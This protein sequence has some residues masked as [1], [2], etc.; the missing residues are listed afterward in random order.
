[1]T[2]IKKTIKKLWMLEKYKHHC[3]MGKCDKIYFKN[4]KEGQMLMFIEAGEMGIRTILLGE[5]N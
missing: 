4:I 2:G 1:M 5:E 3:I